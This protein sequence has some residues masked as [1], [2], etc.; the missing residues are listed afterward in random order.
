QDVHA[1]QAEK[2]KAFWGVTLFSTA[3]LIFLIGQFWTGMVTPFRI[4]AR[5]SE[6]I[7]NGHH[8]HVIEL[9]RDD[10]L[11]QMAE[12]VNDI[13]RRFNRA[14]A[15]LKRAKDSAE[16]EVRDR[17]REVIQNEQL[18][19]VGFL[20]AGVAHEINNPLGAIA[21]SAEA[22]EDEIKELTD[23][24]RSQLPQAL[25]HELE[26][27]LTLIQK[28]A[29]RC[30]GITQRLLKFSKLDDSAREKENVTELV[31]HVVAMVGK[32]GQYR[33]K[34]VVAHAEEQVFAHCNAQEIQQVILNLV[35]NALESVD[36]EGRVDV[37]VRGEID[38][39]SGLK[40]ATVVVKDNGCGMTQEVMDH[41]FE[42][43]FTRRRDNSGTGLGLSISYRI[44]SIHHGSLTAHSGGEGLGS[45]MILRLPTEPP[46]QSSESGDAALRTEPAL[47]H[48]NLSTPTARPWKYVKE[49]A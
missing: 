26:T 24:E 34:R 42:P 1:K 2:R 25:K 14:M 4:L 45:E 11:G 43:F 48:A 33:C 12:T 44:V 5:G 16:Q 13:T 38:P 19:S 39:L 35:S 22:I 10:E 49:V 46:G 27:N 41:L 28:E 31:K 23:R 40:H 36:T 20:A 30:K 3:V 32:V 9:G 21:W 8:H 37:F 47:G 18:A 7:A 17:T 29:Y 15:E 6:L